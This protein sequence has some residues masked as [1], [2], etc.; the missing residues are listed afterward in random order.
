M[1]AT[2]MSR[3][4]LEVFGVSEGDLGAVSVPGLGAF[5]MVLI[6]K[7]KTLF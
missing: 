4:K 3:I 6:L 5:M 2:M 1:S 7:L